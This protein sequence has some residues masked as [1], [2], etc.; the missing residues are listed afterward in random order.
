M[1]SP[2]D[3]FWR[4]SPRETPW[5][6]TCGSMETPI[7]KET[8]MPAGIWR[9]FGMLALGALALGAQEL[10][11]P[12]PSSTFSGSVDVRLVN[13]EAVVTDA[14][15]E[16]VRGLSV[17]DFVLEVD[18][19]VVPIEYFSEMDGSRAVSPPPAPATAE[20]VPPPAPSQA[21]AG[22]SL[23]V[24]IDDLFSVGQQRDRML[25]ALERDLKLLRPEDRMA[26]VAFFG[27]RV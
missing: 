12:L 27:G 14:K 11:P 13:V 3:V 22:R 26:I 8:G 6:P 1:S 23:L 16:R 25:E 21:L 2:G 17:N 24:F 15:G 5:H 10:P 4:V 18:G 7:E 19:Q 9:W 20:A